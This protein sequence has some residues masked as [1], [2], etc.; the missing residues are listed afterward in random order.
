MLCCSKAQIVGRDSALLSA[1]LVYEFRK[2][3]GSSSMPRPT[4]AAT[5]SSL[6]PATSFEP[7]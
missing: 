7:R 4:C 3:Q 5:G 2:L 6:L 1:P